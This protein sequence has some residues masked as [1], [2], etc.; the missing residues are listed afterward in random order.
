VGS[1]EAAHLAALAAAPKA[2]AKG[3]AKGKAK[4][5]AM[6]VA[7]RPAAADIGRAAGMPKAKACAKVAAKAKAKA[8]A[9]A[10]KRPRAPYGSPDHPAPTTFYLGGKVQVSFAKG[11]YRVFLC[12]TDR[13]DKAVSWSKFA[14]GHTGAFARACEMIEDA[15]A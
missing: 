5:K 4:A 11:A 3:K 14:S 10:T 6:P 13:V 1:I 8:K 7:K 2:K 12:A 9:A 15:S